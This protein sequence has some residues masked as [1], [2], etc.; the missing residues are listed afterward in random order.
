[1]SI[2]PIIGN[3]V[4]VF[5]WYEHELAFTD[6]EYADLHAQLSNKSSESP[7]EYYDGTYAY[8]GNTYNVRVRK[9]GYILAWLPYDK[10][11]AWDFDYSGNPPLSQRA[12][13][14]IMSAAGVSGFDFV[15][16]YYYNFNYP[17]ATRVRWFGVDGS[18]FNGSFAKTFYFT[19]PADLTIH[20]EKIKYYVF[21]KTI[22][23]CASCGAQVKINETYLFNCSKSC[24]YQTCASGTVIES[25]TPYV[26]PRGEQNAVFLKCWGKERSNARANFLYLVSD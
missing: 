13:Q 10:E 17:N 20:Y 14:D 7:G 15:K 8:G 4:G 23:A 9:D 3:E 18:A 11:A 22:S 16:C 5:A 12:I 6:G 24:S 21:G 19:V 25:L 26:K 2:P 1:M